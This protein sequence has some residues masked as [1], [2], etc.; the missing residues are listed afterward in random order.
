MAASVDASPDGSLRMVTIFSSR[1]AIW[2]RRD[3][4]A[5]AAA[6]LAKGIELAALGRPAT[7]LQRLDVPKPAVDGDRIIGEVLR[8]DRFGNLVTNV[9]RRTFD[10]LSSEAVDIHVGSHAVPCRPL[11]VAAT[12]SNRSIPRAIPSSKSGGN[13]TPIR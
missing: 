7:G 9:D 11:R 2:E 12:Q 3:R 5:P 13:P 10:R 6:W 8:V 1:A 4:F